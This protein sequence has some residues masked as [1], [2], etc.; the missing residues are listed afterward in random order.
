MVEVIPVTKLRPPRP[1]R[2]HVVRP[3]L[4][5]RLD[6][7]EGV[8]LTVVSAPAGYGK[9]TLLTDWAA[10]SERSVAW[11]TLDAGDRE[12][13]TLLR[14]VAAA[15]ARSVPGFTLGDTSVESLCGV[16]AGCEPFALVVDDAHAAYTGEAATTLA[17]IVECA[18]RT[19]RLVLAGRGDP[20]F[21]LGALR[22]RGELLELGARDLRLTD[23]EAVALAGPE[24][25]ARVIERSEGWPAMLRLFAAG[26]ERTAEA[27]VAELVLEEILAEQ[28]KARRFLMRTS[29][30]DRLSAPLC[31]AVLGGSGSGAMLRSLEHAQVLVLPL[32]D[33]DEWFRLH[34]E[35]RRVLRAELERTAP[36]AL[37]ELHRRAAAWF[38]RAGLFEH[39]IEHSLAAG[40]AGAAGRLILRAADGLVDEGKRVRVLA[41]V[42]RLP[43]WKVDCEPRLALLRAR[44]LYLDGRPFEA[45]ESLAAAERAAAHAPRLAAATARAVAHV[46]ASFVWDDVGA[47][48]TRARACPGATW[49]I[50]W[51]LWWHG[52][53]EESER[54]LRDTA[55]SGPT[56]GVCA[57]QAVLARI[58][59][60]HGERDRAEELARTAAD[61]AAVHGLDALPELGMIATALGAA[62]AARGA[63]AEALP[64]L[65]RGV[66]LRRSSG[67][68]L[69]TADALIAAAP[70]AAVV[71]GRARAAELIA[72]A[73]CIVRS[74]ADPGDL[75]ARLVEAERRALP[76]PGHAEHGAALSDR[77]LAVLRLLAAGRSKRE[78]G[79]ELFLSFNTIHS[80][81]KAIYRKLGVS[82]RADALARA[83]SLGVA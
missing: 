82:T 49:G 27:D 23:L 39:A 17:R 4:T 73:R 71:Q 66:R 59:L 74:C 47:A 55:A 20:P 61:T 31:D 72:E 44:L 16:A 33:R 18:P 35:A 25:G 2:D 51:A 5:R 53:L 56:L 9:T 22:A 28:P 29:V 26:D 37:P 46:R 62:V 75:P 63:H 21:P 69:E 64:Q 50:G 65:E 52:E 19:L 11:L 8:R 7:G 10:R 57:A 43:V 77:E 45:E 81:T 83:R 54:F 68:P 60:A 48:L 15:L 30:L 42:E 32:D 38:V 67:H 13:R 14:H 12:P 24:L 70:S 41:W 3:R 34:G 40:D 58:A 1:R 76:R 36:K 79:D 80:H 6:E 78:I